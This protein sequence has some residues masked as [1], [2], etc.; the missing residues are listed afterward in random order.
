[1]KNVVNV[2]ESQ[3]IPPKVLERADLL[4]VDQNINEQLL[5]IT[6]DVNKN[7]N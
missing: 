1:M 4:G 3:E 2:K 7:V 5:K 6:G